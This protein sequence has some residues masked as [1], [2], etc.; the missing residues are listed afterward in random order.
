[1]WCVRMLSIPGLLQSETTLS[2]KGLPPSFSFDSPSYHPPCASLCT[3]A[4]QKALPCAA[5][6]SLFLLSDKGSDLACPGHGLAASVLGGMTECGP[7]S[8]PGV[9]TWKRGSPPLL[10]GTSFQT[11]VIHTK[12]GLP[13]SVP[14]LDY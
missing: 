14:H 7:S 1:M 6:L 8:P 2:E 13:L 5:S 3:S 10:L 11:K 4:T 12:L 9:L